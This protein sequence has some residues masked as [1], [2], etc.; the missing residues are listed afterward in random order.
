MLREG[1]FRKR[2]GEKIFKL[3]AVFISQGSA[4]LLKS[5]CWRTPL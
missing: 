1:I 4:D 5:A 3:G 2:R